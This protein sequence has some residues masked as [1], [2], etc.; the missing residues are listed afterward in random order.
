LNRTRQ[1]WLTNDTGRR[2]VREVISSQLISMIFSPGDLWLASPW[3]TDFDLLDN[4]AGSWNALEVRW[5]FRFVR[6]SEVLIKLMES[7]CR[8]RIVTLDERMDEYTKSFINRLQVAIPSSDV[9]QH[10][11]ADQLHFKGILGPSFYLAGSMNSTYSGAYKNDEHLE[12][13]S[14]QSEIIEARLNYEQRYGDFSVS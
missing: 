2:K 7:G 8:L 14:A 6:F 3:A 11:L 10:V 1:F 4:R 13:K 9:F 12:L 5:G